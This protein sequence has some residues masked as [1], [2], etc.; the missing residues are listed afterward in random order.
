[1]QEGQISFAGMTWHVRT[2]PTVGLIS[3]S[4]STEELAT[5]LFGVHYPPAGGSA[6]ETACR[7]AAEEVLQTFALV[8]GTPN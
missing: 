3:Y 4:G 5:Y 8:K 1:M 7:S 6:A 2:F